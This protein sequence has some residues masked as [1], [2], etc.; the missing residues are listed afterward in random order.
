[1]SEIN[2]EN[3]ENLLNSGNLIN[4]NYV[5]E[6]YQKAISQLTNEVFYLRAAVKTLQDELQK[7]KDNKEKTEENID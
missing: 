1:M 7:G 4:Y 2:K 3:V 6:E 5:V